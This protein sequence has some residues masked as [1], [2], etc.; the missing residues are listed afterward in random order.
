VVE[1]SSVPTPDASAQQPA[2]PAEPSQDPIAPAS[3]V[4]P[5]GT[6]GGSIFASSNAGAL[7]AVANQECSRHLDVG[8]PPDRS[9]FGYTLGI[10]GDLSSW[11]LRSESM[12]L[13]LITGL[14]GFGLLG[15]LVSRFVRAPTDDTATLDFFGI[16]SRGVSAAVVVFLAAYGGLT[17]F[18]QTTPDPN[19]FVVFLTCLVG[20]VFGDDVWSWAKQWIKERGGSS[21]GGKQASPAQ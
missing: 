15:A 5:P 1:A 12:P 13:A 14:V 7:L 20:A 19:P 8:D 9:D 17:I 2:R 10:A 21:G 4:L 3:N 11:L 18:S 16:V 6:S